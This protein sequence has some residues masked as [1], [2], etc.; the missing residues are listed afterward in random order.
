MEMSERDFAI[1]KEILRLADIYRRKG[2]I[3]GRLEA[4]GD[5][6]AGVVGERTAGTCGA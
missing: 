6:A 1:V 2:E 4:G 5:E 3:D